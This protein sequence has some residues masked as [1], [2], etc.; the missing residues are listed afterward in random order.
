MDDNGDLALGPHEHGFHNDMR[1]GRRYERTAFHIRLSFST[2]RA[3]REGRI[4]KRNFDVFCISCF[5]EKPWRRARAT[6]NFVFR[7]SLLVFLFEHVKLTRA[8]RT[9]MTE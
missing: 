8:E 1:A 2:S 4:Q 3:E 5:T 6:W 7:F 9:C